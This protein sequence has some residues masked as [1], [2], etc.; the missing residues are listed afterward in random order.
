MFNEEIQRDLKQQQSMKNTD[1]RNKH[2]AFIWSILP[3]VVEVTQI[4]GIVPKL[5]LKLEFDTEDQVLFCLNFLWSI[6]QFP[7][8]FS[9]FLPKYFH[10][11]QFFQLSWE[12]KIEPECGN[13]SVK[14][15]RYQMNIHHTFD[16]YAWTT[17]Y[18]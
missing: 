3:R 14:S 13:I 9:H 1:T 10:I 6:S 18:L 11:L 17:I 15:N 12:S 4:Y 2:L 16:T 8:V 5:Y 7:T